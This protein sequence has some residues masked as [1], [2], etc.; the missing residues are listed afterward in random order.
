MNRWIV[1]SVVAITG[2]IGVGSSTA[3][4]AAPPPTNLAPN[5]SFEQRSSGGSPI[6]WAL[7]GDL[8]GTGTIGSTSQAR[9]GASAAR[10]EDRR[11]T[12]GSLRLGVGRGNCAIAVTSGHLYA[13]SIWYRSSAPV[14][15]DTSVRRSPGWTDWRTGAQLPAATTWARAE[16]TTAAI[17]PD[18]TAFSFGLSVPG[19]AWLIADDASATDITPTAPGALFQPTFP[20]TDKLV[21][22][23]YAYWSPTHSDTTVSP[24]WEM[25]SGSLFSKDGGGYSGR[26]DAGTVDARSVNHTDSAVFRLNTKRYDFG[27]VAVSFTLNVLELSSTSY[28]PPVDWDGIHI[29]LRYQSQYSLYYASVARRDGDVVIK[30]KC[31][32]GPSNDGTYYP[33]TKETAGYPIRIGSWQG[34]SASVRNNSDGTVT[35]VLSENGKAVVTATDTGVGCAPITRP[36]AVGIRGD[37]VRFQFTGFT[38]NAA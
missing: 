35:I 25:T 18:G 4:I 36:G 8:A 28:T 3:A 2:L 20:T 22:N 15:L 19:G 7:S 1:N 31:P 11:H 37:N 5:P 33:L 24:D 30:K 29:F 14:R 16:L 32:G 26:I 23:E 34:V 9:T 17:P 12:S 38:V 10:I 21:T 27:D 13:V 6:C